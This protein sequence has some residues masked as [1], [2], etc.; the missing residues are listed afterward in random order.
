MKSDAHRESSALWVESRRARKHWDGEL[1]EL[2]FKEHM[3][4][5]GSWQ[6][7]LFLIRQIALSILTISKDALNGCILK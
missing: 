2:N 4:P 1:Q 3:G 7:E 5:D 6:I